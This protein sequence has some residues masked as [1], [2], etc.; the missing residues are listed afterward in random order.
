MGFEE[1]LTGKSEEVL[2]RK[3]FAQ[4]DQS[5]GYLSIE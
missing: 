5:L 3:K 1:Y 2:L 4:H